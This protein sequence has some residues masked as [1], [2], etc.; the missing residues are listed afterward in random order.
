M[1]IGEINLNNIYTRGTIPSK[2]MS[3]VSFQGEDVF[4]NMYSEYT[5]Y[6]MFERELLKLHLAL[7]SFTLGELKNI[8]VCILP[9]PS[10][11]LEVFKDAKIDTGIQLKRFFQDYYGNIKVLKTFFGLGLDAVNI[12]GKL[13]TKSDLTDFPQILFYTYA[14]ESEKEN[15]DYDKLNQYTK[16]LKD[17]GIT[18]E[19]EFSSKLSY[20]KS[21]FN[22]F[23]TIEDKIEAAKYLSESYAPK[24][25][26][27]KKICESNPKFSKVN[28]TNLYHE[29]SDIV[30]YLYIEND[31]KSLGNLS[32][33]IDIAASLK[34]I[35]I[36][37]LKTAEKDFGNLSNTKNKIEFCEFLSNFAVMPNDFNNYA[38]PDVISD[39]DYFDIIFYKNPICKGMEVQNSENLFRNFYSI[40]TALYS[41]GSNKND[42]IDAVNLALDIISKY[43]INNQK[44]FLKFYNTIYKTDYKSITTEQICN[45]V[46][47]FKYSKK[48]NVLNQAKKSGISADKILEQ[49]KEKYKAVEPIIENFLKNDAD[50]DFIGKSALDVYLEYNNI[51]DFRD[52]NLKEILNFHVK[53]NSDS[54]FIQSQFEEFEEYF[55]SKDEA[56]KFILSNKIK[57][58]NSYEAKQYCDNCLKFLSILSKNNDSE[59]YKEK[60]NK[61]TKSGFLPKS[62][63]YLE[64]FIKK[65]ETTEQLNTLVNIIADTE[66]PSITELNEFFRKYQNSA[67]EYNNVI[68][69]LANLPPNIS[70]NRY[71]KLLKNLSDFLAE[72][73]LSVAS[74]NN[75]NILNI[76]IAEYRYL[77]SLDTPKLNK[78][79]SLLLNYK[80]ANFI[81]G[82][83]STYK[84]RKDSYSSYIIA[85]ELEQN[86]EKGEESYKN[87]R[88]FFNLNNYK[89]YDEENSVKAIRD[90]LPKEFINFVNSNEWLDYKNN[91]QDIPNLSLHAKLRLLDR[92]V[93]S[94][95]TDISELYTEETIK[96][97]KNILRAIYTQPPSEIRKGGILNRIVIETPLD[98]KQIISVFSKNGEL[99]TV[100]VDE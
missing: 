38:T 82:L 4:V 90:M 96:K 76:N 35:K 40:L 60:I 72:G 8:N 73:K 33:Y 61:L 19:S 23:S 91:G 93:M 69:Q 6:I 22:D 62:K 17:C 3:Q 2:K 85:S 49:R 63:I 12:Y 58:Q 37:R 75:D 7:Q 26:L 20:L 59:I 89:K 81:N 13:K 88:K 55:D 53:N 51:T 83:K 74:V 47:L 70:F 98:D 42:N 84:A 28:V 25:D 97:L 1:R 18:K 86:F 77:D 64:D 67:G 68:T 92:T 9:M 48:I 46:E 66:V 52:S 50:K 5:K 99:I 87:I 100:Y 78:L 57:L 44:E 71:S 30:N 80:G 79:L 43:K 11:V 41:E 31:G 15:P 39:L 32:E 45:F 16:V 65:Y 27:L 34:K 10:G 95:M 56:Q 29:I 24:L 14:D 36:N 94:E 21:D 54:E